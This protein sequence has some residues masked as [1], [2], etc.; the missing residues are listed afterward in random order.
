MNVESLDKD[1]NTP[2]HVS[3]SSEALE[4]IPLLIA[5]GA[6]VNRK[7]KWGETPLIIATKFGHVETVKFL[8]EIYNASLTE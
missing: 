7:N 4:S 6:D 8:Y 2:L 1:L 3:A 5:F